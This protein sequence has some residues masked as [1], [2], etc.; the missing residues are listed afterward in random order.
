MNTKRIPSIIYL[1]RP[2]IRLYHWAV[3]HQI[4]SCLLSGRIVRPYGIRLHHQTLAFTLLPILTL[5]Q[6]CYITKSLG[7]QI[8]QRNQIEL[9][10]LQVLCQLPSMVNVLER[11]WV[12]STFLKEKSNR[13]QRARHCCIQLAMRLDLF[14]KVPNSQCLR[15]AQSTI[16]G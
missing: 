11:H 3:C 5:T 9:F 16:L 1:L 10:S 4:V 12:Q 13:H 7:S 15:P 2:S 14:T 6:H 8:R